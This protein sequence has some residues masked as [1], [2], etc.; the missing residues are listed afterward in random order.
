MYI[1]IYKYIHTSTHTLRARACLRAPLG[2]AN[3]LVWPS[4]PVWGI[5]AAT[6]AHIICTCVNHIIYVY[7]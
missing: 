3:L 6:S 7:I 5:S 4:E 1:C 2:P